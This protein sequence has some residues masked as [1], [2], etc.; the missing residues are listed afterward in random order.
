[1]KA[2]C[3]VLFGAK[4]NSLEY[5][6]RERACDEDLKGQATD[7]VE[8]KSTTNEL[9]ILTPYV[10]CFDCF[11]PDLAEV[12]T[13]FGTSSNG[14][15]VRT[16]NVIPATLSLADAAMPA[17]ETMTA[18]TPTPTFS[19]SYA[20]GRFGGRFQGANTQPQ[21]PPPQGGWYRP[22]TVQDAPPVAPTGATRNGLPV[23][24]NERQLRVTMTVMLVR[25]LQNK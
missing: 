14:F 10:V 24:L 11:S 9:A 23:M 17:T 21:T 13:G 2:I 4:V 19:D 1:M 12:L 20:A 5:I 6:R 8:E 3:G 7:Y 15:V 22:P 25:L 16:I 18:P